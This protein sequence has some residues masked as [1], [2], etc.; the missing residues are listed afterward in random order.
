MVDDDR[1]VIEHQNVLNQAT[2]PPGND[3]AQP[4]TTDTPI[5]QPHSKT[6]RNVVIAVGLVVVLALA[7]N[8]GYGVWK[9]G[10]AARTEAATAI[11]NAETAWRDGPMVES[12]VQGVT[13]SEKAQVSLAEAKKIFDSGSIVSPAPYLIAKQKAEQPTE[14]AR[15]NAAAAIKDAERA[16]HDAQTAVEPGSRELIES[17]S[18]RD[19]IDEATRQFE[20]GSAIAA[21]PYLQAR[22]K[23]SSA[24]DLASGI[25]SRVSDMETKASQ[26]R[27][28]GLYFTLHTRY[29]RTSEG[30]G[31]LDAALDVLVE[32]L[33]GQDSSLISDDAEA[34][35]KIKKFCAK[36]PGKPPTSVYSTAEKRVRSAAKSEIG[37]LADIASNNR[38]WA[39]QMRSG[40]RISMSVDS[41]DKSD[42]RFLGRIAGTLAAVK[43]ARYKKVLALLRGA[44][45]LGRSSG[46]IHDHP[47]RRTGSTIYYSSGQVSRISTESR[48][49]A[50]KLSN[51]RKLLKKL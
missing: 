25:T 5:A 31:A 47:V 49:M 3:D 45:R 12:E 13:E 21:A 1:G 33:P 14:E 10:T 38:S 24:W 2:P 43:C 30:M 48:Q 8:A 32:S 29:P 18:A 28:P 17:Q 9:R 15:A 44:H 6:G 11:S 26:D 27:S 46:S 23:A 34:L 40:K 37:W 4:E 16:W 19:D 50:S 51:A 7:G 22:Q 42:A 35:A 39:S 41:P 36:Y 20:R